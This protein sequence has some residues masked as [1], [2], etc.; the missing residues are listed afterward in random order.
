MDRVNFNLE[1]NYR[2]IYTGALAYHSTTR[3]SPCRLCVLD[4]PAGGHNLMNP[5]PPRRRGLKTSMEP[6]KPSSAHIQT[7]ASELDES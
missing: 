3:T 5:L 4:G 6:V 7:I 2:K 1:F